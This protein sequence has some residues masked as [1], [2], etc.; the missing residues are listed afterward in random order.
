MKKIKGKK[1]LLTGG[2]YGIGPIIAET[3]VD[4]GASVAI[5]ARSD[6]ALQEVSSRLNK[7]GS[8]VLAIPADLGN[9]SQREKLEIIV[10]SMPLRHL[11]T[12]NALFPRLGDWL[13][14]VS[15]VVDF[16]RRKVG[17]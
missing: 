8:R 13:M 5:S 3:L 11:F 4:Q 12:L 17:K 2:S 6:G 1:V 14:H 7:Y 16:Q 9:S 15:G 10:N